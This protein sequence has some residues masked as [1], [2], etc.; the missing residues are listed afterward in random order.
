MVLREK[1]FENIMEKAE[2]AGNQP[3]FSAFLIMFSVM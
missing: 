2:S 1:T 3:T